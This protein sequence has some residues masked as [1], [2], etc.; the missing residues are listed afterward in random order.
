MRSPRS[1]VRHNWAKMR[2]LSLH[3][4][5]LLDALL[6]E[7]AGQVG[8][9]EYRQ[10]EASEEELVAVRQAEAGQLTEALETFTRLIAQHPSIASLYNNRAQI[11]L[12]LRPHD[13]HDADNSAWEQ[14]AWTDLQACLKIMGDAP[15]DLLTER[16]CRE[17]LGWLAFR[18]GEGEEARRHF[19]RAAELGSLQARR[20][21]VRCNPYAELCNAMF[22][23]ALGPLFSKPSNSP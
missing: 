7:N 2:E 18:R 5:H 22:R 12:L 17:Q 14:R 19:D 3:D 11:C 23:E 21:A 10:H 1:I 9:P 15:G 8:R 13:N 6:P 20:M 16:Q 4:S